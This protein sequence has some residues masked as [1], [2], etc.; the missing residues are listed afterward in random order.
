MGKV[1]TCYLT[2]I[3]CVFFVMLVVSLIKTCTCIR[4]LTLTANEI[5]SFTTDK[6]IARGPVCKRWSLHVYI[7]KVFC[8]VYVTTSIISDFEPYKP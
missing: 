7:Y 6:L 3:V 5:L 4:I 1:I 8:V 2:R